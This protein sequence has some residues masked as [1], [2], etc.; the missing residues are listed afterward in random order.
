[1]ETGLDVTVQGRNALEELPEKDQ[2]LFDAAWKTA[3]SHH[4]K[5]VTFYLPGMIRYGREK[6]RYPAISITGDRCQLQCQHCGGRLLEP[7]LKI[8][9]PEQ[10]VELSLGIAKRGAHG[11]LLSGGSDLNGRLPWPRY[12]SAIKEIKERTSLRVS[13]HS[14]FPDEESCQLLQEAGVDQALID[15][16][17]DQETAVQ[18]YRLSGVQ[19]VLE[20]LR[21]IKKSG[22]ELVAHIVAGLLFGKM[23]GEYE[24]LEIIRQYEPASLVVVSLTPLKGTAMARATPPS[25]LEVGRL[26]AKARLLMPHVPLSL[27]CERPRDKQGWLLERFALMAGANRIS[28]WSESAIRMAGNLGLAT[29][30]Q[31]T[32]CSIDY[33]ADFALPFRQSGTSQ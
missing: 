2:I 1:M 7:M 25:P 14:G 31:A 21:W 33:K 26:M 18:V 24:A 9:T 23:R 19:P 3:R 20:A 16:I 13:V 27:G 10:L 29:R 11:I 5:M 22:M 12:F 28:I 4:D 8:E 17:G 15:V 6:G 30:F 32:C